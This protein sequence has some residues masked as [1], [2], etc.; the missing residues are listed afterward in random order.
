MWNCNCCLHVWLCVLLG[1]YFVDAETSISMLAKMDIDYT[2]SSYCV[3]NLLSLHIDPESCWWLAGSHIFRSGIYYFLACELIRL[4][5]ACVWNFVICCKFS[6]NWC[7]KLC[8]DLW[9]MP[10][11]LSCNRQSSHDNC[12]SVYCLLSRLLT[13]DFVAH[14]VAL[15]M[16]R[17][18]CNC[19]YV[20]IFYILLVLV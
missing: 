14:F 8:N 15:S 5:L 17:I 16:F 10:Q 6:Q 4:C 18:A 3:V 1:V 20:V 13:I 7:R 19:R 9:F 12:S 2:Y 11:C